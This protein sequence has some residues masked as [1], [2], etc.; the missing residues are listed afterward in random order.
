MEEQM[1]TE[2]ISEISIVE[3]EIYGALDVVNTY[4]IYFVPVF[5]FIAG[6]VIMRILSMRDIRR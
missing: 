4:S 5:L 2:N 3:M 1:L 6:Y